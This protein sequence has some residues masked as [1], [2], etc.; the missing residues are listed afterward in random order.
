MSVF[1]KNTF[2]FLEKMEILVFTMHLKHGIMWLC[3]KWHQIFINF[4]GQAMNATFHI[5]NM[6]LVEDRFMI[7]TNSDKMKYHIFLQT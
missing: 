5:K 3:V 4:L 2:T 1:S 7:I 6:R